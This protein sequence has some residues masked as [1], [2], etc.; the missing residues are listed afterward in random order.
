MYS[1]LVKVVHVYSGGEMDPT[2]NAV[3]FS[4]AAAMRGCS[5]DTMILGSQVTHPLA[6]WILQVQKSQ[7]FIRERS[8][9]RL[10]QDF[11]HMDPRRVHTLVR[12][13]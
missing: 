1:S 3:W 6:A 12:R 5:V 10:L 8:G 9:G 11:P 13:C 4:D 7:A 2:P